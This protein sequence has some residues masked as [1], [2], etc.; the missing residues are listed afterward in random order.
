MVANQNNQLVTVSPASADWNANSTALLAGNMGKSVNLTGATTKAFTVDLG[1]SEDIRR[2]SLYSTTATGTLTVYSTPVLSPANT[3]AWSE[4]GTLTLLPGSPSSLEVAA[5]ARYMKFI[6]SDDSQG[7]VASVGVFGELT[8]SGLRPAAVLQSDS[9]ETS[10]SF[11][12][13]TPATSFTIVDS[14]PAFD[15]AKLM[16][17]FDDDPA[18]V[19][20]LAE[21]LSVVV[22]FGARRQIGSMLLSSTQANTASVVYGDSAAELAPKAT[23]PSALQLPRMSAFRSIG[24]AGSLQGRFA[25]ISFGANPSIEGISFLGP[26]LPTGL[27]FDR[28]PTPPSHREEVKHNPASDLPEVRSVLPRFLSPGGNE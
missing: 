2:V 19:L 28:L 15:S 27:V 6:F 9:V 26:I 13:A 7:V 10:F 5:Q 11:N 12:Y 22:D 8:F 18:T 21:P 4:L 1:S 20:A 14:T 17:L 3:L 23:T 24:A 25:R 16:A